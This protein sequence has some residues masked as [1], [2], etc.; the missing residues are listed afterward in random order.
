MFH[1]PIPRRSFLDS[2]LRARSHENRQLS[3]NG[4]V[5]DT[6]LGHGHR[7]APARPA[8][9]GKAGEHSAHRP[10]AQV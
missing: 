8:V 3:H 7:L 2:P 5:G 9:P 1:V 10:G 6:H 4:A